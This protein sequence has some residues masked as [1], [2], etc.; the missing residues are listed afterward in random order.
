MEN[1]IHIYFAI[2]LFFSGYYLG[3]EY[4]WC[5]NEQEKIYCIL[6]TLMI[7]L[8]ACIYIPIVFIITIII[9]LLNYI[10]DTFQISFWFH[11]YF[12][13]SFDNIE[14]NQ[15]ELL[16]NHVLKKQKNN[17][18]DKVYRYCVS[19]IN[20]KNNYIHKNKKNLM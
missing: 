6:Y 15:L 18:K 3:K 1:L 20:K 17:T 13:K 12:T 7:I 14:K 10:N 16:N 2:N 5:G 8:F 11:F 19:L 4:S 9:S